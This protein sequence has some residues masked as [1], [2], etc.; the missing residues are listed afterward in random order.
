LRA[1]RQGQHL[2]VDLCGVTAAGKLTAETLRVAFFLLAAAVGNY[3]GRS[4]HVSGGR[5]R[6]F[7]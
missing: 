1:I 5:D 4:L 6:P 7:V 3:K 2:T